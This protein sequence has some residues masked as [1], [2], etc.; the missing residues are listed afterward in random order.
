MGRVEAAIFGTAIGIGIGKGR[1]LFVVCLLF[2]L[3][4]M[5]WVRR[6]A[7]RGGPIQRTVG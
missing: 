1:W 7:Q 4:L 5:V 2:A 3:A 6:R